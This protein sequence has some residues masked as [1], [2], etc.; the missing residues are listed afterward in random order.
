MRRRSLRSCGHRRRGRPRAVDRRARARRCGRA[1]G[2]PSATI[3]PGASALP[4]GPGS[5]IPAG[6]PRRQRGGEPFG[7]VEPARAPAQRMRRHR[8]GDGGRREQPWWGARDDLGG[9]HVGHPERGAELQRVHERARRALE[10][11]RRP[12]ASDREAAA[13]QRAPHGDGS[14]SAG[15]ARRAGS[16]PARG[17]PSRAAGRRRPWRDTPS[18]R[19][20]RARRRGRRAPRGR[21]RRA[22]QAVGPPSR[23]RHAST[24]R[25]RQSCAVAADTS[26][27]FDPG[28]IPLVGLAR[29]S[30]SPLAPGARPTAPAAP[31]TP[32]PAFI[33]GVLTLVVA[34]MSPIDRL[35]EQAFV[36]HMVQHILLLDV[37]PILLIVR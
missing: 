22:R 31:P 17:R 36:M 10:R 11:D 32:A 26:W 8:D 24:A 12:R 28:A 33:G 37:A 15:S 21:G 7:M 18:R 19:A 23:P 30:T 20:G 25:L 5:A 16:A 14:R 9:H 2:A 27:T 34:L 3:R 6:R 1:R 13:G 4:R 35:G 29:P